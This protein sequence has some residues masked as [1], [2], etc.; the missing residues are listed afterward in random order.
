MVMGSHCE[1]PLAA[2]SALDYQLKSKHSYMTQV[3]AEL[4]YSTPYDT[5]RTNQFS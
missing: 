4:Y 1:A 5:K 3:D 2:I